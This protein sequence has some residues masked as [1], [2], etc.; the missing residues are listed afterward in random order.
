MAASY[1][2]RQIPLP[3][4]PVNLLFHD[5]WDMAWALSLNYLPHNR[6]EGPGVNVDRR[7]DI[8]NPCRFLDLLA[9]SILF[10]SFLSSLANAARY[11]NSNL[12]TASG[13][14]VISLETRLCGT[15]AAKAF[16]RLQ[17]TTDLFERRKISLRISCPQT[18]L[19]DI[20]TIPEL[21]F[22]K[23]SAGTRNRTS[24]YDTSSCQTYLG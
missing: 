17:P 1:L 20:S 23:R 18:R 8:L 6:T 19:H 3:L 14:P 7:T 9:T 10:F 5:L 21:R 24:I 4:S 22:E 11:G 2:P 16:C 13:M 15:R 12:S